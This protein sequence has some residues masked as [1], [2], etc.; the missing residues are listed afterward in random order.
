MGG[1][2]LRGGGDISSRERLVQRLGIDRSYLE[3]LVFNSESSRLSLL[4]EISEDEHWQQVGKVL[5]LSGEALNQARKE[6]WCDSRMDTELVAF[7]DSLRPQY[8]TGLLSNAWKGTRETVGSKF[9]FLQVFDVSVFSDE[10]G[11]MKPDAAFYNWILKRLQVQPGE[12][13]FIDDM[14]EN[15]QAAQSLGMAG[16]I[17][18]TR[19]QALKDLANIL[20]EVQPLE[21]A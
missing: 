13:V 10:V 12:A 11:M 16:I 1:V 19:E 14:A 6:F 7:I 2:I 15:V 20:Q 9:A 5:D 18:H 21:Q 3:S 8:K 4:G 17:F